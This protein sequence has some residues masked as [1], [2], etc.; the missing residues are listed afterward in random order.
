MNLYGVTI[1]NAAGKPLRSY[2]FDS[3]AAAKRYKAWF[4]GN[5]Y[6]RIEAVTSTVTQRQVDV[7]EDEAVEPE[8]EDD[9][10]WV[11]ENRDER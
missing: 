5:A 6:T 9:S 3:L 4:D 2:T 1:N 10:H 8:R 7:E 11:R